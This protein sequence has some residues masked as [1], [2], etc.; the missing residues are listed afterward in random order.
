MIGK[1]AKAFTSSET[2][3]TVSVPITLTQ[4]LVGPGTYDI[5]LTL[6]TGSQIQYVYTLDRWWS[7]G[8]SYTGRENWIDGFDIT[9]TKTYTISYNAN[10]GTGAPSSQTKDPNTNLTLSSTQPTRTGYTFKGWSTS[11]TAT[12][13]TY[14]AGGT[15]S[16]DADTILYAV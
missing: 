1:G 4:P 10:G 2:G 8:S 14:S 16:T 5:S 12:T 11:S 9:W 13:P 6:G 15:F 3:Q 7:D